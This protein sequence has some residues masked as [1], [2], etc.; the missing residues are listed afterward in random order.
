MKYKK[1]F[2]TGGAGFVGSNIALNL[3]RD[4]SALEIVVLDNLVRKGSEL[5]LPRLRA[6]GISFIKGDVRNLE[7]IQSVRGFDLLIECSAEP[8]VSAGY[9]TS[10]KYVVDTNLFGAINCLEACRTEKADFIFLSTSRVYPIE[11]L[12]VLPLKED[13]LR[14]DIDSSRLSAGLSAKGISEQFPLSGYRSFYGA[15]KL[16][17]EMFIEEYA[18]AY[19]LSTVIDRF[20]VIAGPWQMGKIDQGVITLWAAYHYFKKNLKYIGFNG[21]QVRDVLHIQDAY[22]LIKSQLED[23]SKYQGGIYNVGGGLENSVSLRQLT[24]LCQK[25]TGNTLNIQTDDQ[26]RFADIPYY[27]TDYSKLENLCRFRPKF[28]IEKTVSDIFEWIRDNEDV[29]KNILL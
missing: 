5:N 9:T 23:I 28:S 11:A 21:K 19:G 27:V 22:S 13:D 2:I 25:I 6:E 8:S 29:L 10:P 4:Y 20:G 26:A 15:S 14:F 3:K 18:K 1:V 16:S 7:D 24:G 12:S 17:A